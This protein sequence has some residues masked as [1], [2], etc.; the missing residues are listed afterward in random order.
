MEIKPLRLK[1]ERGWLDRLPKVELHVHLEGAIPHE[2]FWKLVQKYG[3]DPAVPDLEALKKKFEYRDFVHFIETW[4]WKN[5]FLREYEDFSFIA[6]AVARGFVLQNIRYAE[7]FFS[8]GDFSDCGLQPQELA[9]AVR[10]G[11]ARVP[12]TRVALVADLVRDHGPERAAV[13]LAQV[14]EVRD[15]G[16]IGIG[17]GGSEHEFPPEPFA[18]IYREARRMGFHTSAHAGE[19]AGAESVWGAVRVLGAERIGHGT[20]ADE[21]EVLIDHLA[22]RK[23]PLEMCPLSNLKTGIIETIEQHPFRRFFDR[24]VIVTVNTDDPAM[25]GNSLADEYLRLMEVFHFSRD[26]IRTLGLQAIRAS[27]LTENEKRTLSESFRRDPSW[28]EI[29]TGHRRVSQ[30]TRR[31]PEQ[32][33]DDGNKKE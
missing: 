16:V 12:E 19:A 33:V 13:T 23:I 32:A 14:R 21:D 10:R 28:M 30:G 1:A 31:E 3:G 4:T 8:P 15:Q 18:G 27:W 9:R 2:A 7:T 5:R 24:G 17:I 22:E 11:L 6:E 20:R 29:E 26:E 25:F